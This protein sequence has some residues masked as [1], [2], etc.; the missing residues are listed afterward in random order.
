MR[1]TATDGVAWSVFV[2]LCVC[3]S[4]WWS[5]SWV[6]KKGWTDRDA[7]WRVDSAGPI[8]GMGNLLGCPVHWKALWVTAAVYA[9]N[10]Q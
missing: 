6:C 1:L 7:D 10:N 5:H 2:C 3:L 9:A 8:S 4:L